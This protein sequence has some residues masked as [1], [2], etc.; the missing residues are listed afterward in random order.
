MGK[1]RGPAPISALAVTLLQLD[2]AIHGGDGECVTA[3]Q[4]DQWVFINLLVAVLQELLRLVHKEIHHL[5]GKYQQFIESR[6]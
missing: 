4:E 2:E 6:S 5:A 3:T 1:W